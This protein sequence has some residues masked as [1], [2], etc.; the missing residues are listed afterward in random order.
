MPPEVSS[1]GQRTST[2]SGIDLTG[3]TL[4]KYVFN[5]LPSLVFCGLVSFNMGFG[6]KTSG[7]SFRVFPQAAWKN[8]L[9]G[10]GFRRLDQQWAHVVLLVEDEISFI[11]KA[12]FA[13]MHFRLQQAKLR[14][15]SEAGLDLHDYTFGGVSLILVGDF[16]QLEPIDDWSM[17]D[18][19]SSQRSCPAKMRHLWKHH[20]QGELLMR[21]FDEAVMLSTIHR[22]KDDLWWTES[23]LRLRDF[24]C[25]KEE[26]WDW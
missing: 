13:R 2:H 6:A 10:D 24:T 3:L 16:G 8:E 18:S 14:F 12:F 26:D 23:C 17:C 22:S 7:S 11:G 25:T 5:M 19:E 9:E 21:T 15:S 20:R 1:S 4:S